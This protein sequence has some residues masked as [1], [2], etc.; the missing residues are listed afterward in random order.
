MEYFFSLFILFILLPLALAWKSM[1]P[2]VPTRK[3]DIERLLKI[4]SLKSWDTFF[5]IGCGDWRVSRAVAKAYPTAHIRW[6][7]IA[8]PMWII[9]KIIWFFTGPKNCSVILWNAF[10]QNF[11]DYD[12]IYVYWMPD[13]MAEKIVPKFLSEAKKWAK[14]YSYVF[15]IPDTCKNDV[16]SYGE[17]NEAKIHV[18]EK[19]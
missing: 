17:E 8:Y 5:E 13:K 9:A 3:K 10:K 4:L 6:L 16:I 11:S 14:L 1:A 15:S 2:W 19:K 12:I 7:E 18:L